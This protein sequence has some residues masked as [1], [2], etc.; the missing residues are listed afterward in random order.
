MRNLALSVLVVVCLVI[1]ADAQDRPKG[2]GDFN[3]FVD[4]P[5]EGW[6]WDKDERLDDLILQL[7]EK[8]LAL[9][10]IDG[11]T[12]K[13]LGRQAG[14]KMAENMAWRA[15][16]RMDLNAGGP[17]RWDAFYGRN[18]ENFFYHPVDPNTTYHTNTAMQQVQP[19]SAGGV[20]F[21]GGRSGSPRA[22]QGLHSL[23]Q[24]AWT[25]FG[26]LISALENQLGRSIAYGCAAGRW[27]TAA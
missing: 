16:D 18:A 17:I 10:A 22:L 2:G 9:Q 26:R 14:T 25:H 21:K 19:T 15:M 20:P 3:A 12:A 24:L 11:R 27:T 1:P 5:R 8:E 7:Q 4:K 6:E 23:L 13:L